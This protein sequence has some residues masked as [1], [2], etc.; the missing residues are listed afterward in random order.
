MNSSETAN[1][2][3]AD[4]VW[5]DTQPLIPGRHYR[6][7]L[8]DKEVTASV[9]AIKYRRDNDTGAHLAARTLHCNESAR[10][11]LHTGDSLAFEHPQDKFRL[12]FR[13]T[14]LQTGN[15][16]GTGEI[17]FA[18]R[19]AM[20]LRWQTLTIDKTIRSAQKQ[21]IPKCIWFTGLS[22]SG[23]S[24]IANLLEKQLQQ[25]NKHPYL[26]DGDNIRHGLCRDLGFTETDRVENIRRVSEV[27]RL[28]V[29]A[30][31]IVLVSFISPFRSERLMARQLFTENEFIEVFVDT[32]LEECERRDTKGL[33]AK[34]RSGIL[35]NFT[36]IDSPYEPPASPEIHIKTALSSAEEAVETILKQL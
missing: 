16:V 32:Q 17:D 22:G 36:G 27:S 23:K 20:N 12:Q 8:A 24:T 7:H 13:L 11:Y 10:I 4:L 3:E 18:L 2:F 15:T 35:K 33:Y 34:A 28:M 5:I 31:L 19:R 9:T 14:D 29:D 1:H 25:A 21:Q 6:L 26:L 30:G